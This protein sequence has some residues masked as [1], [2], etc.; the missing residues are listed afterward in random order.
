MAKAFDVNTRNGSRV[1]ARM[2]GIEST[3][4]T[5]SVSSTMTSATNSG[6]AYRRPSLRTKKRARSSSGVTG[7]KRRTSLAG[8]LLPTSC[9]S[10]LPFSMRSADSSRMAPKT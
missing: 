9:A 4:K 6:V 7:T 10:S 8:K 2:A 3:A 1:T 5:T